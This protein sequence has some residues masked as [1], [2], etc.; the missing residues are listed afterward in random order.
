[1]PPEPVVPASTTPLRDYLERSA[2]G[3]TED[4]LVIPRSLAQSMPLRWQQV[5]VGLLADLHDAYDHLSWPEY[6]VVACRWEMLVDL[7]EQQAM[8]AGYVAELAP[9][10]QLEY[11]E[12][13]ADEP[14]EDPEHYRVLAPVDD[15]LPPAA[16]G[17]VEPRPAAPLGGPEKGSSRKRS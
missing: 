4:H 7:D 6:K 12:A 16:A 14:V 8:A 5:F 13:Q 1:M 11:R 3:A 2:R 17:R 9:D 10:G 15:P